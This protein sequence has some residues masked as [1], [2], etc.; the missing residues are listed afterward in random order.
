MTIYD[1]P[2]SNYRQ[3]LIDNLSIRKSSPKY[4]QYYDKPQRNFKRCKIVVDS[5]ESGKI[6]KTMEMLHKTRKEE[7]C[8]YYI[9]VANGKV[10]KLKEYLNKN[11]T[12]TSANVYKGT[13]SQAL[14]RLEKML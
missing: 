5:W 10:W 13:K 6:H 9:D 8:L 4:T 14:K 2:I 12:I 3:Y 11:K 7:T 1:K